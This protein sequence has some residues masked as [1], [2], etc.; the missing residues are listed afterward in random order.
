MENGLPAQTFE[1]F[2]NAFKSTSCSELALDEQICSEEDKAKWFLLKISVSNK[3]LNHIL[4]HP[5]KIVDLLQ[6]NLVYFLPVT[7]TLILQVTLMLVLLI[8]A[9][10]LKRKLSYK[11]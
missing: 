1:T 5:R 2:A 11:T 9:M 4:G 10:E 8:C 7:T 3:M 6:K